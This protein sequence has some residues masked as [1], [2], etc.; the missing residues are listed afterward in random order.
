MLRFK[1]PGGYVQRFGIGPNFYVLVGEFV[2]DTDIARLEGGLRAVQQLQEHLERTNRSL[3]TAA[4]QMRY[5]NRLM[6]EA[7]ERLRDA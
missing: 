6:M 4:E 5:S 3:R 2:F 7:A 1:P